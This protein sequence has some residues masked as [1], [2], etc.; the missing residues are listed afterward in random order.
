MTNVF[1]T[2][3]HI[4][5]RFDLKGSSIG[6]KVLTGTDKDLESFLN[7]DMALK[8]L[9]FN[10]M[11]EKIVVGSKRDIILKQLKKD[12]EFLYNINSNDYSLLLGIHKIKDNYKFSL[13][14]STT[15]KTEYIKKEDSSL[16]SGMS[17]EFNSTN[18]FDANSST[19]SEKSIVN[20]INKLKS[21]YDFEDGGI[22]SSNKNRIYYLGIIDILTEFNN[23][24]HLEYYYKRVRY[25]SNKMSCIPPI[26]YKERFINYL[27]SVFEKE[28]TNYLLKTDSR[29][30]SQIFCNGDKFGAINY[31]K[32]IKKEEVKQMEDSLQRLQK[33][34]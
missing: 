8:D 16:I 17:K 26:Q 3:N 34:Q 2:S 29:I 27:D 25:C 22:L 20:R 14:K 1:A 5:L 18:T 32:H 23:I 7:G 12:T 30:N 19:S 24:K 33:F 10:I 9:D 6:R 31:S 4:D 21:I 13:T 28:N 15:F 11:N